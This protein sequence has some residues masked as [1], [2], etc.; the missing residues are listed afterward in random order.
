MIVTLAK[1]ELAR[2]IER[3]CRLASKQKESYLACVK[4]SIADGG[5]LVAEATDLNDSCRSVCRSAMASEDGEVLVSA[6]MLSKIVKALPEQPVDVSGDESGVKIACGRSTFGVPALDPSD[7]PGI[8]DPS[9]A[10]SVSLDATALASLASQTAYAAKRESA[11]ETVSKKRVMECVNL[12]CSGGTVVAT[13]TDAYRIARS[14]CPAPES[15]DFE[16]NVP[17]RMLTDFAKSGCANVTVFG[18]GTAVGLSND[19]DVIVGRAYA[20]DFPD[21]D[22]VASISPTTRAKVGRGYL[23]EALKRAS[24]VNGSDPV[25]LALD[26]AGINVRR[27]SDVESMSEQVDAEVDS[28]AVIAM[29]AVFAV[30]A[31]SHIPSAEVVIDIESGIRPVIFSGGGC[32]AVVMPVRMRND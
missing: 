4:L 23:L 18:S 7:F 21:A 28:P 27:K 2:L 30:E 5:P 1:S 20:G 24:V 3:P 22:R 31:V 14:S 19:E 32:V 11:G 15:P 25:V 13:A 9:D 29:N 8:L 17:A 12:K 26:D 16:L 10:Q 6:K